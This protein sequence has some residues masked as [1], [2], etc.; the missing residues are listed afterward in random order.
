MV[1]LALM[2][3]KFQITAEKTMS[4]H[5]ITSRRGEAT[6]LAPESRA[7]KFLKRPGFTEYH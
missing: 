2:Q 3:P 7:Q 5:G 4:Y 1:Q 6:G